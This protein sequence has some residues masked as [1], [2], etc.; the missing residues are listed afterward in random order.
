MSNFGKTVQF[1]ISQREILAA[2]WRE[3][4][5]RFNQEEKV[6]KRIERIVDLMGQ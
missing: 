5:F 3:A 1:L 6:L 4:G 2:F